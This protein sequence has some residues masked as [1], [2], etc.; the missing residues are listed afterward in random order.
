MT[1]L[2]VVGGIVGGYGPTLP[3]HKSAGYAAMAFIY[4]YDVHFSYSFA[5]IGWVLPSEIFN[6]G[7][8]SKAMSLTTSATWIC[9][10]VIGLVTPSMLATIGFGTYIFFAAFC[11]L[12]CAF[13]WFFVPET[14][15]RSMDDMDGVFGD[16]AAHEEKMRLFQIAAELHGD[17]AAVDV[18]G[19]GAK[20]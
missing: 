2:L 20:V 14:R 4:I 16:N 15:G 1:S 11:A 17:A 5:P 19:G 8:R 13:T 9:N 7:N 10:F 3:T 12:A 18:H 6:L